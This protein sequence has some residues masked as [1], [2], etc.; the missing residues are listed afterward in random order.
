MTNETLDVSKDKFY[1]YVLYSYKDK[2]FYTGFTSDLRQRLSSHAR[3]EVRSTSH[4][5]PLKL[6]HYEYFIDEQ[7]AKAREVFL[8]SGFGREQLKKALQ[9]T[10]VSPGKL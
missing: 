7:D 2:N 6:I 1:V 8:K 9:R 4:R 10:L 3:G 5:R